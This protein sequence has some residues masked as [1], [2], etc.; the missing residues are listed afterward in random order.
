VEL[1]EVE[2][3]R[4][5]VGGKPSMVRC[6]TTGKAAVL[7]WSSGCWGQSDGRRVIHRCGEAHGGG[8][9][10]MHSS[11]WVGDGESARNRGSGRLSGFD[12]WRPAV[13]GCASARGR[14]THEV[15]EAMSSSAA[16]LVCARSRVA[17]QRKEQRKARVRRQL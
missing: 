1:A 7:G 14:G 3:R 12:S 2:G 16:Q 11:E 5:V 4:V 8:G 10:T 13:C 6:S 15:L 9:W 17:V